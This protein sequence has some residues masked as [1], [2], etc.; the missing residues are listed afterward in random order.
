MVQIKFDERFKAPLKKGTKVATIRTERKGDV[1]DTFE[2][3][4]KA[5]KFTNIIPVPLK[6]DRGLPLP[7]MRICDSR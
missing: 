7:E 6:D 1:G 2:A 4:G 5:Y 3:F